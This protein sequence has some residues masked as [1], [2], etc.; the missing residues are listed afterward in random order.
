M[1]RLLTL[2]ALTLLLAASGLALQEETAPPTPD[3]GQE[4][5]DRMLEALGGEKRA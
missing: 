1:R 3:K 2:F 4:T 5:L